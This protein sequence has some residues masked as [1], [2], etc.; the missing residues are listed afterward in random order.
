MISFLKNL[1]YFRIFPDAEKIETVK[2]K[3]FQ[4][5]NKLILI[6]ISFMYVSFSSGFNAVVLKIRGNSNYLI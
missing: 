6:Y 4:F 3:T 5:E 1:L 2:S